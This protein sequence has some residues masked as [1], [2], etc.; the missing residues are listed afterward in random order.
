MFIRTPETTNQVA[1]DKN[2]DDS[3]LR[4]RTSI[5]EAERTSERPLPSLVSTESNGQP[6]KLE[7]SETGTQL[8]TNCS[9]LQRNP[10]QKSVDKIKADNKKQMK[11]SS[12]SKLRKRSEPKLTLPAKF[13][14]AITKKL[15]QNMQ[16]TQSH[17]S[18]QSSVEKDQFVLKFFDKYDICDPKR[19]NQPRDYVQTSLYNHVE[20]V[21]TIMR[22]IESSD[23][24]NENNNR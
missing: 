5:I 17:K 24:Y 4:P 6:K 14:P 9:S 1:N 16:S 12:N 10:I 19:D 11:S 13:N 22:E 18:Q 15:T 8:I 7:N 3:R 20:G 21:K 23:D 2:E